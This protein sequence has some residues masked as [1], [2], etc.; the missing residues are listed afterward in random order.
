LVQYMYKMHSVKINKL[1]YV[2][3]PL[4][5]LIAFF[6]A[7]RF[8]PI[9]S[10]VPIKI[11]SVKNGSSLPEGIVTISG[12]ANKATNLYING[13]STSVTKEGV[14]EE[15]IALP[16]GYNI[17]TIEAKDKFGKLSSKTIE[18]QVIDKDELTQVGLK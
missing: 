14:F 12:K 13:K 2:Y 7:S 4:F 18:V 8:Y 3:V 9:L 6:V 17:V 5:M 16:A 10:K 1:Y 15:P 11:G